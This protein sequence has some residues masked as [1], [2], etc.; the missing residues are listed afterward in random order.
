MELLLTGAFD[1]SEGQIEKLRNLGFN[2]T[3]W[4]DERIPVEFDCGKFDTVVCNGLF[5]YTDIEKFINLK[6]IQVTSA[7][8]DRLPLKYI[9]EK[10]IKLK[11]ARGV[12][13]IPMA[14]WA[15]LK[16]LEIYKNTSFFYKN[17]KEKKWLKNRDIVELNGKTFAVF[18]VGNVGREV[19]KRLKSFGVN[20]IGVYI[21]KSDCEYIDEFYYMEKIGKIG[22]IENYG[23]ILKRVD[24]LILTLPLTGKTKALVNEEFIK[25]LKDNCVMVNISR[26]AVIDEKALI[27][28]IGK[29]GGVALDVF[30]TEPLDE[31][32]PLWEFENVI[33]SPHNSFVSDNINARL[34][35]VIYENLKGFAKL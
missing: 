22:K 28:G 24:G 3:F 21:I 20:V 11:N 8:L 18:G 27:S 29:F 12:Y 2:I 30:E 19:A 7:G 15:I 32:S 14:E 5:L 13:S 6:L 4:R 25:K 35:D 10:N 16:I 31:E 1:Y 9:E 17:Q 23:E 34:F 26:G 33:I